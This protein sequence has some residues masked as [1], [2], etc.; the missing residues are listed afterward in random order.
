[1]KAYYSRVQKFALK[2]NTSSSHISSTSHSS[3]L[4]SHC[5]MTRRSQSRPRR[6]R[7]CRPRHRS[8][9]PIPRREDEAIAAGHHQH[10]DDTEA[11]HH[12]LQQCNLPTFL[13]YQDYVVAI[14]HQHQPADQIPDVHAAYLGEDHFVHAH[15][16]PTDHQPLSLHLDLSNTIPLTDHANQTKGDHTLLTHHRT[17]PLIQH[18]AA[19]GSTPDQRSPWSPIPTHHI[20]PHPTCH[21][22]AVQHHRHNTPFTS[23]HQTPT[24]IHRLLLPDHLTIP[25]QDPPIRHPHTSHYHPTTNAWTSPSTTCWHNT[26]HPTSYHPQT[27][28]HH[29]SNYRRSVTP[30]AYP[31]T[32]SYRRLLLQPNREQTG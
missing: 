15:P 20:Q 10:T 12:R 29:H 16:D 25:H 6:S 4:R 17:S 13:H 1:M 18:H 22:H 21:R 23:H 27:H 19:L 31:T 24:S 30:W 5:T 3:L 7:S 26:F 28:H 2:H 9:S 32:N 14:L 8:P 11:H